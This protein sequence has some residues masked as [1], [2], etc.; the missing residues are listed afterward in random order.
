EEAKEAIRRN[1]A[2][3]FPYS[4]LAQAYRGLGRFDE[5]QKTAEQAVALKI[6]TL[7]TRRLLYQLAIVGGDEQAAAR[8]L[9]WAHGNA[10]EFDMVGVRAQEAACAGRVRDA[11]R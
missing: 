5:A 2:H 9:E 8:Q 7:P 4:N 10:R 1:P 3:G 6:E 11:R